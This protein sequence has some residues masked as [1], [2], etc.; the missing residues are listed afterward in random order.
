MIIYNGERWTAPKYKIVVPL[1]FYDD[2]PNA[3]PDGTATENTLTP[4][5]EARLEDIAY[6]EVSEE[7]ARDYVKN[8]VGE[9]PSTSTPLEA[10][11]EYAPPEAITPE[12]IASFPLWEGDDR[13][14]TRI[15]EIIRW[16]G[17]LYTVTQPHRSQTQYP[18]GPGTEA[19]YAK[20]LTSPDGAILDWEPP[21]A[22]N[23]YP[24]GAKVKHIGKIW[25]STHKGLNVWEPGAPGVDDRIWKE[26]TDGH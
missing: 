20:L 21:G 26:V 11:M 5:Q 2:D 16:N 4:E 7:F 1:V 12:I 25:V 13:H 15:G 18:P 9:L 3:Y 17:V 24:E 22:T 14:Y 10:L 19:L 23:G 6:I 8:G